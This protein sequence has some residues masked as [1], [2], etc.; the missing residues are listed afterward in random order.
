[1]N[2]S[3]SQLHMKHKQNSPEK[4]TFYAKEVLKNFVLK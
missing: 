4:N 1:M 2:F 3:V